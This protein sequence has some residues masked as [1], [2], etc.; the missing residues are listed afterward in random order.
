MLR[1]SLSSGLRC[2]AR[3]ATGFS[4]GD[5]AKRGNGALRKLSSL[6]ESV[7][8]ITFVDVNVRAVHYKVAWARIIGVAG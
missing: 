7:V 3:R 5:T 4:S 2:L 8:Q 6:E 1:N